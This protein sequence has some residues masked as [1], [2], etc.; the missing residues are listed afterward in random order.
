MRCCCVCVALYSLLSSVTH[1]V[2]S[3]S[4]PLSYPK[5][6]HQQHALSLSLSFLFLQLIVLPVSDLIFV[7]HIRSISFSRSAFLSSYFV[8]SLSLS[9]WFLVVD[10]MF[11]Y[12]LDKNASTIGESCVCECNTRV[13]TFLSSF[14]SRSCSYSPPPI[15]HSQYICLSQLVLLHLSFLLHSCL[16]TS[17]GSIMLCVVVRLSSGRVVE[18]NSFWMSS[19]RLY[20]LSS[21]VRCLTFWLRYWFQHP[22]QTK[23]EYFVSICVCFVV[24]QYCH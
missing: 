2:V 14:F 24:D 20:S 7:I 4:Q 3:S 15:S 23:S 21:S 17:N 10:C 22:L 13:C 5:Y 18:D 6:W 19:K 11:W 16:L 12:E 8:F 1:A 9:L